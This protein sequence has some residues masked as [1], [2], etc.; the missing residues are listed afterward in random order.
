MVG[1]CE[2]VANLSGGQWL[3]C[4]LGGCCSVRRPTVGMCELVAVLSVG[5][6]VDFYSVWKPLVSVCELIAAL[7]GGQ[8][9]AYVS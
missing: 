5:V 7:S 1:V 2:L 4:E 9:L 3:V 8:S 6:C